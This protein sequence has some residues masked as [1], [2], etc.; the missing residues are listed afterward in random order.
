M[1]HSISRSFIFLI[2]LTSISNSINAQGWAKPGAK[3]N[4]SEIGRA[5]V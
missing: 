2:V 5:H 1:G 4:Y 3:W